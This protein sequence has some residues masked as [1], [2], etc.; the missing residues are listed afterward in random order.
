M[1]SV[2][3]QS[4]YFATPN[5]I[6]ATPHPVWATPH[7]IWAT[8][9]PIWAT[10]HPIGPTP[11]PIWVMLHPVWVTPPPIWATPHP[12]WVTLH[13]VWAIPY[14]IWIK[15]WIQ[16]ILAFL[17][18]LRGWERQKYLF[19]QP[20]GQHGC[21]RSLLWKIFAIPDEQI[22]WA[23]LQYLACRSLI[24]AQTEWLRV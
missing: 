19:Q 18:F 20:E 1:T 22:I 23:K 17:P 14:P 12:V 24:D 6:W 13:P 15:F 21:T 4:Q 3:C 8:P 9:H 11:H 7:P 2:F 10:P 16:L 5:P